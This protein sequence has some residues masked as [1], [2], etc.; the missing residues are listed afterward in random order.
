MRRRLEVIR[1]NI[2]RGLYIEISRPSCDSVSVA[3]IDDKKHTVESM[4]FGKLE[5]LDFNQILKD[6]IRKHL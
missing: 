4:F 2:A 3:K 5:S 6:I 1:I